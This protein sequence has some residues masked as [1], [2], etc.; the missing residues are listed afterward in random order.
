MKKPKCQIIDPLEIA[1]PEVEATI[2]MRQIG[3]AIANLKVLNYRHP[4]AVNKFYLKIHDHGVVLREIA[5]G[6]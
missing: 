3:T 6:K 1:T 5:F 4:K 2:L